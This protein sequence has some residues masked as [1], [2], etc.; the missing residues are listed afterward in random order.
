MLILVGSTKPAKVEAARAAVGAVA[1]VDHRFRAA[2]VQAVDVT[3]VAPAMPM[4]EL[5][6]LEGARVRARSLIERAPPAAADGSPSVSDR[7]RRRT[8]SP[9]RRPRPVCAEN[10]GGGN[11]QD[12]VVPTRNSVGA[13][14][15][16]SG[17]CY[18][19]LP[20]RGSRVRRRELASPR[21]AAVHSG[22]TTGEYVP[23]WQQRGAMVRRPGRV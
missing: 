7:R 18:Q 1:L 14:E 2:T 12:T 3:D 19:G 20:T 11:G 23:V 8:R 10:L 21:T 16:R 4:T 6:I 13:S 9:P 22:R 5:A 17:S 15:E